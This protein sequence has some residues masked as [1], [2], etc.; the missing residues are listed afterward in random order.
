MT[1]KPLGKRVL[2]LNENDMVRAAEALVDA[3]LCADRTF[4]GQR[5]SAALRFDLVKALVQNPL[6]V[7]DLFLAPNSEVVH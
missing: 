2:Q 5:I 1:R 7:E 6:L 3:A 4:G